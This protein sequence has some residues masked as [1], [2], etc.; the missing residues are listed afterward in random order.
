MNTLCL[1]VLNVCAVGGGTSS[2]IFDMQIIS[3]LYDCIPIN[4]SP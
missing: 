1:S 3:D 4:D 2:F